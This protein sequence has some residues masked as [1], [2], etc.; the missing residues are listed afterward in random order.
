MSRLATTL[1]TTLVRA[2]TAAALLAGCRADESTLAPRPLA[3]AARAAQAA[4]QLTAQLQDAS[5]AA[6]GTARLTEDATG[7]VHL[8]VHVKGVTPGLHGLHL[9]AVGSCVGPAFTSAGG[10]YNPTAREHGHLNPAGFHAGDLPNLTVNAAGVGQLS[11]TVAQFALAQLQDADGSALVL[12]ANE[13]DRRTNAGPQ[14]P[15]NS[16]ARIACGVIGAE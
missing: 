1:A 14:G 4:T 2:G 8:T 16:G 13:D 5:G 10:H 15:G 3:T 11:T 7:A 9:H 12:H 6:I